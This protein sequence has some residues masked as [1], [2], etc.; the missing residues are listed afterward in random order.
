MSWFSKL[1]SWAKKN[2][3]T[4]AT[5]ALPIAGFA[6]GLV[7][8]GVGATIGKLADKFGN[9]VAAITGIGDGKPGVFGIG[10]GLPGILGIGTGKGRQAMIDAAVEKIKALTS[11]AD[12]GIELSPPEKLELLQAKKQA[13]SDMKK[14]GVNPLFLVGGGLLALFAFGGRSRR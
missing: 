4:I 2:V 9:K 14:D 1:G 8:P 10:D 12:S 13:D 6:V 5:V 7:A 11:K 3:S